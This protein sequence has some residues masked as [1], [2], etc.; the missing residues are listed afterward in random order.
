MVF[1]LTASWLA[2][3]AMTAS[4]QTTAQTNASVPPPTSPQL[5]EVVVTAQKRS[6]N[7]MTV[8][9]S[10]SQIGSERLEALHATALQDYAAYVPG[11]QVDSGGT[12][13]QT[14]I[15]LRGIAPIGPGAA[16]GTYI[17][18]A[19]LGSSGLYALTNSFQVDLLPY[20]LKNV[21][22]LRGPQG[23]LYGASTMGGLVKYSLQDP[24]TANYHAALGGDI[25]GIQNGGSIGGGAR[26]MVNVPLVEDMLA[27]RA[28][29][30]DENTPGYIDNPVSHMKADNA[31]R[32]EGGRLALI[33]TPTSDLKVSLDGLY[34]RVGAD[35]DAV[36]ALDQ[37]GKPLL[38]DLTNNL[39]LPQ[40]FTQDISLIKGTISY[41]LPFATLTSVTGY[42]IIRSVQ[43]QDATPTFATLFPAFTGEPG[44][45]PQS[46]DLL[47]RK[48]TEEVRL[49]SDADA[50]APLEWLIGGF[51]TF[52]DQRNYPMVNALGPNFKPN[53]LD[54]LLLASI[55]STYQEEAIFGDLT[56][57]IIGGW[58]LGGGLR[59]SHNDQNNTASVSGLLVP[60]SISISSQSS[61]DVVTYNVNTKYQFDPDNLAY[62]RIATGYQPGGP[63][64]LLPGVPPTVS[65][66]TLTSY[67][68]GYKAK[69]F[70]R[71][72]SLDLSAFRID[73][74]KIQTNA[75]TPTGL[76]YLA[77]G[78]TAV[79]QGFE[80]ATQFRVTQNLTVG[81]TFAYTDATFSKPVPTLGADAGQRLPLVPH[82][83]GS[84]NADYAYHL[85]G[86][87]DGDL[88]AGVRYEGSRPAYLFVAPRP[89]VDFHEDGYFALDLS[90]DVTRDGWTFG[91][92][93]KNITDRRAYLTKTGLP[94]A[95]TGS[96]AQVNATLLQPRTIGVSVDYRF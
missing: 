48:V 96:I 31:V 56:W 82:Y 91:L 87:W 77:N 89:P 92:F 17:D 57:R 36:V 35:N 94:D 23:T 93:A 5:E 88:T 73:W 33:W 7:I 22:V 52:E 78:G 60:A 55:P 27:V 66:S 74:D 68:I 4:A 54:P 10:V 39:S 24:D 83:S 19:P 2:S 25:M 75:T 69:L 79:S 72:L 90:A 20:D 41:T 45:A 64:I 28:S 61:E 76:Q 44:Y 34:Q 30:F 42:S 53:A 46:V 9:A 50:D 63:N 8:P 51:F 95:L 81:G 1:L 13:G 58:S 37:T 65:S 15:T 14:T 11:L 67:E 6:E 43:V 29:V 80:A 49:A 40:T 26:G 86:D 84:L 71:R 59:Y 47:L 32:Q 70:E 85:W 3:G 18:D 16:V 62:G 12:P 21:E 38:G